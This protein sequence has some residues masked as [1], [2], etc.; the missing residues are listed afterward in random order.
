MSDGLFDVFY[1]VHTTKELWEHIEAMY[2]Q[3]DAISKK[4]PVSN[5]LNYKM[6]DKRPTMEQFAEIEKMLNHF[7][8][9]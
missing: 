7:T 9:T 8:L 3:E 4:F 1:S 5:F 2:M 6:V